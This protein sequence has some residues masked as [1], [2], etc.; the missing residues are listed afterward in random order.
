M[1]K[2]IIMWGLFLLVIAAIL[3]FSRKMKKEIEEKGIEADAVVSRIVD[4]GSLEDIDINVYV[5]Y[6]TLDG[7][8][9][10]GILSNPTDGLEEGQ[11]VRIKY[12]PEYK[13]NARLI[14]GK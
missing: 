12:H 1:D 2:G 9:V 3:L 10:E 4:E 8:E 5:R 11:Q 14:G 7:E 6:R 13:A